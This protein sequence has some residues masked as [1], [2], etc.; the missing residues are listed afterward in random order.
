MKHRANNIITSEVKPTSI[1]RFIHCEPLDHYK[2][3]KM[4]LLVSL[5]R[6]QV[7]IAS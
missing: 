3:L 1:L 2:S 4:S 7:F 6:M 5:G